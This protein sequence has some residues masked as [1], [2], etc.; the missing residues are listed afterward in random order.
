[1]NCIVHKYGFKEGLLLA[2]NK[3]LKW[4]YEGIPV[5]SEEE[6]K[7]LREEFLQATQ[8]ISDRARAYPPLADQLDKIFHEGIDAWKAEIQAIKDSYPKPE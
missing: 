7:V 2:G 1:M 3:V 8:Y 4:P 6:V 5:P